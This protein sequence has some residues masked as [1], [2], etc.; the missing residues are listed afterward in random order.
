MP[1]PVTAARQCLTPEAAHALD[2]AVGVARRRGHGQTTSLHAVSAL[3]SLPSS[4]LRDACARARNS[5]YSPR[6]QFKALD[7][8]LGV[9]LDR[10]PTSQLGEEESPPVSNSLMAAIKRSQ[11]NQ[12]RQPEH[13]HL[14]LQQ[15]HHHHHHLSP[16]SSSSTSSSTSSSS[17]SCVKVELQN[18]ILSILDDP[19][20]SRVFGEAGFRSSEIKMAIV[21][22]LPQLFKYSS[23]LR[24][25]PVFL[26]NSSSEESNPDPGQGTCSGRRG[27]SFPFSGFGDVS[28]NVHRRIGEVLVRSK[29]R[30][31][32][33]VGLCAYDTLASFG[34]I[35]EKGKESVLGL[36][37]LSGL[38]MVCLEGDVKK[39]F[40]EVCDRGSV[41]TRFEE[42]DQLVK[43]NLGP[44]LVVNFG[45]LKVFVD[46]SISTSSNSHSHSNSSG[47]SISISEND[48][49]SNGCGLNDAVN[50]VVE[51]LTRLLQLH[52][53]KLW[54]IGA[55]SSYETY[56]KFVTRF[57]SAE[58]DWDLQVMPITSL[59]NS[60]A[61][62]YPRS[63]LMESFVPFGGFFSTTSDF[64]G[65]LS[66]SSQSM[67]RCHLCNEKCE[68]EVHAVLN[69]GLTSSVTDQYQS[70][71]PSYLQMGELGANKGLDV[72]TGDGVVL[73][74][75]VAGVQKKWDS[76]CQ[77]L[78]HSRAPGS[79]HPK[80]PTIMG[81]RLVED[82]KEDADHHSGNSTSPLLANRNRSMNGNSCVPVTVGLLNISPK[83]I[84]LPFPVVSESKTECVL[85]KDLEKR[86]KGEDV[87]S[88]GL[89]SSSFSNSSTC[90]GSQASPAT[91][92]GL[93]LSSG[94]SSGELKKI[95]SP[96][97]SEFPQYLSCSFPVNFDLVSDNPAQSSSS[98]SP[99]FGGKLDFKTLLRALKERVGWQ[100]EAIH[101]IC[102]TIACCR[103]RNETCQAFNQRG[104]IWLSFLGP[105]R[106]GKRK[107][108]TALAEIIYGSKENFISVDLCP[109]DEMSHSYALASSQHVNG[110]DVY[111]RGK[112]IVDC[113]A[114]E[115]YK[116]PLSIV[117][118][119]NI[120]KADGQA[121]GKLL[122]A[123]RT[124]KFSDSYGRHIGIN[125]A[126]FITTSLSAEDEAPPSVKQHFPTYSEERVLRAKSRPMRILIEQASGEKL[127]QD[128]ALS[129]TTSE[130]FSSSISPSKRKLIGLNQ[131]LEQPET[132]EMAKR[133]H[134][135]STRNLDLNL[136]V[137]ENNI[138]EDTR[139]GNS[140]SD[141]EA[142]ISKVWLLDFF[143]RVDKKVVFKPFDFDTLAGRISNQI[144][145]SFHKI[146]GMECLLEIDSKLMEQL[147]ASVYLSDQSTVMENWVE[148]VLKRAFLEVNNRHS[149]NAQSV[150]KLVPANG[151]FLEEHLP[152]VPPLPKIIF[153]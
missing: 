121:R 72:K 117:F 12:R 152:G 132:T 54:L 142:N 110:H 37:Q 20:V 53:E 60:M 115:L 114:G 149:L 74:T 5:A 98:S 122:Q 38:R 43:Q 112:T 89:R 151:H 34:D 6:L 76:I 67:P 25:P 15:Q 42:L 92:L 51:K 55:A 62:V 31:P 136:P 11:A 139:D 40:S 64:I 21:R 146:I 61:E 103:T 77:R 9:S 126:I 109:E 23:R 48:S 32:L 41:D 16:S 39:F 17:I 88:D 90:D 2:E 130:A 44:G 46:A 147:L 123:M 1:T 148:N 30:N 33:L 95:A 8:C 141:S 57:P 135:T 81:F 113:I 66:S 118:L 7:L 58:K 97:H 52:G 143:G 13:I 82:R 73:N 99:T 105:D 59:R 3:L 107:I 131:N 26:W 83:Q 36:D 101:V 24:P 116:K 19:V 119:E 28:E 80:L 104:D 71:L 87:E 106:W 96:A 18:L 69:G 93:G 128:L 127:G 137:E 78:H 4:T 35:L 29:G 56:S 49:R 75:K 14:Y 79:I 45:D 108:A 70:S 144:T 86:S 94:S 145:E 138:E 150:V 63:S 91:D 65:P 140:D 124:G 10:V 47:G 125:H 100:D 129:I 22:P 68:Q 134:R 85:S 102:Q 27:F 84:N 133:A 120:D 111:S 50:Y 153:N